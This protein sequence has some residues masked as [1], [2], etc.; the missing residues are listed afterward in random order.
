MFPWVLLAVGLGVLA[1]RSGQAPDGGEGEDAEEE[2]PPVQE[3]EREEETPAPPPPE[4]DPAREA[5]EVARRAEARANEV[6]AR[7]GRELRSHSAPPE[8]GREE[9]ETPPES[10][11]D[12]ESPEEGSSGEHPSP[13]TEEEEVS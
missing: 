11:G 2:T 13:P 6:E 4:A 3:E 7:V 8:E 9:E 5:L 1:A 10:G 12:T